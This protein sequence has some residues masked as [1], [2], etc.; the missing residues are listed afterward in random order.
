MG[1]P[2]DIDPA[3]LAALLQGNH[4]LGGTPGV[5][6]TLGLGAQQQG[7]GSTQQLQLSDLALQLQLG[8]AG[9][10]QGP[11]VHYDS[12]VGGGCESDLVMAA[13]PMALGRGVTPLTPPLLWGSTG[14]NGKQRCGITCI[15]LPPCQTAA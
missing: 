4:Y 11:S 6:P 2:T 13:C 10:Q 12:Q 14:G 9:F 8:G 5:P 1:R 15:A 3:T 7:G